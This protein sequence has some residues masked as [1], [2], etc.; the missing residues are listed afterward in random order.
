MMSKLTFGCMLVALLVFMILLTV[1]FGEL[2]DSV[3]DYQRA[4]DEHRF[5][6][7][8]LERRVEKIEATLLLYNLYPPAK[9]EEGQRRGK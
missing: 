3:K 6:I 7:V 5:R 8:E 2:E 9:Y 1:L 4:V